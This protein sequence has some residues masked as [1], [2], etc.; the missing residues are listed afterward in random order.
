MTTRWG[1]RV[2][3]WTLSAGIHLV[4]LL[5]AALVF[6]EQLLAVDVDVSC[7]V[8]GVRDATP[9]VAPEGRRDLLERK[10]VDSEL[11]QPFDAAGEPASSSESVDSFFPGSGDIF[12]YP[13][14]A[15]GQAAPTPLAG[16]AER[17]QRSSEAHT[18]I[19][20]LRREGGNPQRRWG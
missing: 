1:D 19:L 11:G 16:S 4:L 9:R 20:G 14:R 18:R 2:L 6:I 5:G 8:C 15:S 10:G 12:A 3:V 13:Y 17:P 7:T